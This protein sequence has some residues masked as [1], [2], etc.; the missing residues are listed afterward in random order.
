[1]PQTINILPENLA[2]KIA[3]GEVVQR[4]AAAVKEL[5]ENSIDAR[6]RALTLVI[7]K[8]GK[9]LI[10][11]ID[12]GS[13]M[14]RED[15]LLAFQRHATSKI[16]SFEDLE[17]IHT[18]GFRGE[19]LASIAAVAQ[20]EMRT[21][22]GEDEVGTRV[23]LEGGE[24]KESTQEAAPAGTSMTLK[25][26]FYNTPARRNFLKSDSTELKHVIDIVQRIALSHPALSLKF[27]S[28]DEVVFELRPSD[29]LGRVRAIFGEQFA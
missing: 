3:A 28:D 9:S 26:L 11:L 10:Q 16:S 21:K 20:V 25:N 17:N 19:A 22:R 1:M 24:M 13:G 8:G 12:D 2:N 15:A 29:P 4:P 14:S 23:R 6:A 18:L 5:L 7:K 27:I